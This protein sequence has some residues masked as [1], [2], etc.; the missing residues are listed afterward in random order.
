MLEQSSER[1]LADGL[2]KAEVGH[3][4]VILGLLKD[5]LAAQRITSALAG[6]HTLV[7][8]SEA[9]PGEEWGPT[10]RAADPQLYVFGD[11]GTDIVTTD[12]ESYRFASGRIY[13]A[14]DLS[15]AAQA[16]SHPPGPAGHPPGPAPSE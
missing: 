13:P 11:G 7:L 2:T 6:R 8:C 10:V 14:A 12:G 1:V 16:L 5:A 15:A 3:R 4:K 9:R